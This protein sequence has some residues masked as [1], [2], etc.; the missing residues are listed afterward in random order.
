MSGQ[1]S[2]RGANEGINNNFDY[3]GSGANDAIAFYNFNEND[4][5][6]DPLNPTAGYSG[7]SSQFYGG[8][9]GV[10]LGGTGQTCSFSDNSIRENVAAD[11]FY[12]RMQLGGEE[13]GNMMALLALW[14]KKDFLQD[15]NTFGI[16]EE[17]KIRITIGT[18]SENMPTRRIVIKNNGQ[19]YVSGTQM[20]GV[21]G[22]STTFFPGQ[23]T[24]WYKYVPLYGG[25]A[26]NISENS[27]KHIIWDAA[28]TAELTPPTFDDVEAIGFLL[29]N[30]NCG[31]SRCWFSVKEFYATQLVIDEASSSSSSKS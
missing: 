16:D 10:R 23:E 30:T 26:T 14:L 27:P 22:A 4:L 25:G 24:T 17:S 2:F 19:Y 5:S 15:G 18:R 1:Q 21:V 12:L 7:T 11:E 6:D 3:D 9:I 29:Q 20:S 8:I 13:D 28:T 31:L